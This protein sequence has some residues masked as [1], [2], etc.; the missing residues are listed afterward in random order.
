MAEQKE[1]EKWRVEVGTTKHIITTFNWS[2]IQQQRERKKWAAPGST[3]E[4]AER[5]IEQMGSET[6]REHGNGKLSEM[7]W[8]TVTQSREIGH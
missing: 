3:A 4:M 7:R 8:N 6:C 2:G 5:E 1:E